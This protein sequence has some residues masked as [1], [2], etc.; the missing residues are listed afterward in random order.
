MSNTDEIAELNQRLIERTE[1]FLRRAEED[2]CTIDALRE[3]CRVYEEGFEAIRRDTT[4]CSSPT[5]TPPG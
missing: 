2:R 3:M 1:G 4:S 5:H